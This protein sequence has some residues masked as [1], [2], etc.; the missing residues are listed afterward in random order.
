VVA[1]A[2]L[3]LHVLAAHSL[4]GR[5]FSG[6]LLRGKKYEEEAREPR[7]VDRSSPVYPQARI[8]EISEWVKAD[9]QSA[10]GKSV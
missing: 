2:I 3:P 10:S 9:N 7:P 8:A 5:V 1:I 6:E 4:V